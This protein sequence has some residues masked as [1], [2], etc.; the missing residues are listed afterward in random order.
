M[1]SYI[2]DD[3]SNSCVFNLFHRPDDFDSFFKSWRVSAHVANPNNDLQV[4][5]LAISS[6]SFGDDLRCSSFRP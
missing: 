3:V 5:L 6:Y 1:L 4:S 2:A